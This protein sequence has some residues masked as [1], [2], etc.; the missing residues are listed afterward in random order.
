VEATE[1]LPDGRVREAGRTGDQARPPA[2]LAAAVAD[3]AFARA[4]ELPRTAC[5]PARAIEQ[6][7]PSGSVPRARLPPPPPP[8]M[9]SRRRDSEAPRRLPDRRA[10][11]DRKHELAA[12]G[13]S[14]L[15]VTVKLHL[16][17][18]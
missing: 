9:R 5:R 14:E 3:R 17:L 11:L 4:R 13:E 15:G 2:G 10:P 16:A 1:H 6:T 7:H 12:P 8:A 18:L